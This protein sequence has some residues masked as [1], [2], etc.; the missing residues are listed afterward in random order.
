[1][2]KEVKQQMNNST[3]QLNS[4]KKRLLAHFQ[5][6]ELPYTAEVIDHEDVVYRKIDGFDFEISGGSCRRPFT[7]YVWELNRVGGTREIVDTYDVQSTDIPA[8]AAE[9]ERI[10]AKY[11]EAPHGV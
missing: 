10:V 8:A 9:I 4:R 6:C 5:S 11:E 3:N 7:V 1:M 2:S